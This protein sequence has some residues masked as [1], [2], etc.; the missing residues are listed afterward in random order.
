MIVTKGDQS[1]F[2]IVE[3]Y[4][5]AQNQIIDTFLQGREITYLLQESSL[6]L[7]V[8]STDQYGGMIDV[9]IRQTIFTKIEELPVLKYRFSTHYAWEIWE[10]N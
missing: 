2:F 3:N 5:P 6:V 8:N 1:R 7:A 4:V 9:N 10:T